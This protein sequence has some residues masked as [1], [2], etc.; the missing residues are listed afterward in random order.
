MG[1]EPSHRGWPG[2]EATATVPG[3]DGGGQLPLRAS[4]REMT[5]Q[6]KNIFQVCGLFICGL[7][8]VPQTFLQGGRFPV[9]GLPFPH[10]VLQTPG[11]SFSSRWADAGQTRPTRSPQA[12]MGAGR[13]LLLPARLSSLPGLHRDQLN[14]QQ[15]QRDRHVSGAA[16]HPGRPGRL[17]LSQVGGLA[18]A[19]L[20][21]DQLLGQ[22]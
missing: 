13:L 1:E 15:Q 21:A 17:L 22:W 20:A 2:M 18:P 12:R 16:L 3:G 7:S 5:M 6:R 11:C 10:G 8:R 9:V 14:V 19:I 4:R